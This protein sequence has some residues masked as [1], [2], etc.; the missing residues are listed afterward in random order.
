MTLFTTE[1]KSDPEIQN[2]RRQVLDAC[3]SFV[4]PR[5]PSNPAILHVSEDTANLIGFKNEDLSSPEFLSIFSGNSIYPN[6]KPF[7]MNYGGHQFGTWAGQLG[8]RKSHQFI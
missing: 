7:A 6:T 5:K 2:S 4:Q 3:Y 1:L 8:D